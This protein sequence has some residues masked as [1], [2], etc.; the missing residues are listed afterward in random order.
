MR[1]INSSK[2]KLKN[3]KSWLS[4]LMSNAILL[5]GKIRSAKIRNA[6]TYINDMWIND[7]WIV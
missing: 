6:D 5:S 2:N 3:K 7:V 4:R 1:F